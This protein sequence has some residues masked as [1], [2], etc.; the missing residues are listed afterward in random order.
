MGAEACRVMANIR[1]WEKSC[2]MT[3]SLSNESV[4]SS[5]QSSSLETVAWT[6]QT[7]TLKQPSK[8]IFVLLI[9]CGGLKKQISVKILWRWK[10]TTQ[11]KDFQ[12]NFMDPLAW[13]MWQIIAQIIINKRTSLWFKVLLHFHPRQGQSWG[14]LFGLERGRMWELPKIY[15][16]H[17]LRHT[18]SHYTHLIA[19]F[20]HISFTKI[21]YQIKIMLF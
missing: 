15:F 14:L 1:K 10:I 6:G 21:L 20:I 19:T 5:K 4:K 12:N 9:R 7:S 16:T 17:P 13:I 2:S 18:L 11:N 3:Q 8:F